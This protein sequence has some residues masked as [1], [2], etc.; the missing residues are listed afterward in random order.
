MYHLEYG[1]CCTAV[2]D[3]AFACQPR[4]RSKQ[5]ICIALREVHHK[6]TDPFL[7]KVLLFLTGLPIISSPPL[8]TRSILIPPSRISEAELTLRRWARF[9]P[10]GRGSPR[11]ERPARM[12]VEMTYLSNFTACSAVSLILLAS[13]SILCLSV[14]LY[15]C[16]PS[17]TASMKSLKVSYESSSPAT[18]P[19]PR[20]GASIPACGKRSLSSREKKRN[21]RAGRVGGEGC[22]DV[23]VVGRVGERI[24]SRDNKLRCLNFHHRFGTPR[25]LPL[26]QPF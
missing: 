8:R 22:V 14:G 12:R 23:W 18:A 6:K 15:P 19:T 9:V 17:I 2:G 26:S 11:M 3:S 4:H 24:T 25:P 10:G 5:H 1:K 16:H 7:F 21:Q 20:C 13:M